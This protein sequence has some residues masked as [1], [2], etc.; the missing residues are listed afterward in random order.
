MIAEA[1]HGRGEKAYHYYR[2]IAPAFLE[3]IQHVHR[4]EPYVYS[5]MIAGPDAPHCGEAKNSWLT[6][7]AAWNYVAV[8]QY[9]L[10]I[11]PEHEGLRVFPTIASEIGPFE[12]TRMCR[13][14]TY[15]ISVSLES[16]E[17]AAGLYVNGVLC[18]DDVVPYAQAGESVSVACVV[19]VPAMERVV[20]LDE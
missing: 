6:G 15:H 18:S 20:S 12:V 7:T 10:G 1:I 8:S 19:P 17:Q 4:T 14:A 5:Q 9:L 13:G 16:P 3:D 2:R 11:R